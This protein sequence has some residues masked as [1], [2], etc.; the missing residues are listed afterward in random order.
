M[1]E[2]RK[3]SE[4]RLDIMLLAKDMNLPKQFYDLLDEFEKS[5]ADMALME[6]QDR[7]NFVRESLGLKQK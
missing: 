5:V 2:L 4:I 3:P 1:K 7:L 6:I